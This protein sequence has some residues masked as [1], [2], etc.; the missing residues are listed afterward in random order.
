MTTYPW[1]CSLH[2]PLGRPPGT[3]VLLQKPLRPGHP[4]LSLPMCQG[5]HAAVQ[6]GQ[7]GAQLWADSQNPALSLITDQA[8]SLV[9]TQILNCL[10]CPV[11]ST[12]PWVWTQGTLPPLLQSDELCHT[13]RCI[14]LPLVQSEGSMTFPNLCSQVPPHQY[15]ETFPSFSLFTYPWAVHA[16]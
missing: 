6:T 2:V 4:G 14:F 1:R 10:L 5:A 7:C 15:L 3:V 8:M 13:T 9:W 16:P 12:G 11:V